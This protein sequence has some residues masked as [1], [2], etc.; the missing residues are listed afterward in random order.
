M[1]FPPIHTFLTEGGISSLGAE[2]PVHRSPVAEEWPGDWPIG[3]QRIETRQQ[4]NLED[5]AHC[6]ESKPP[7][8]FPLSQ[9]WM[10]S[11]LPHA[12]SR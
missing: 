3:E 11:P 7:Y 2:V 1:G 6:L 12:T 9:D 4:W 10:A 5:L 8:F